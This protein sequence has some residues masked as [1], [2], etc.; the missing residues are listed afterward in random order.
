MDSFAEI[1]IYDVQDILTGRKRALKAPILKG[2]PALPLQGF[3][4]CTMC[5]R[6]LTGSPSKSHTGTYYY[7]YHA[8]ASY[9]CGCRYRAELVNDALI[10][11]LKKY[12]PLPGMAELY[13]M[14]IA[15]IYKMYRSGSSSERLQLNEEITS[16]QQKLSN[17]R[18]LLMDDKIDPSDFKIMK[19]ECEDQL[20]RL[21]LRLSTLTI[22]KS[23]PMSI[24]R[25]IGK[26]IH[27]LSNVKKTYSDGD[28]TTKKEVLGC[29][30]REKLK[31][32]G[33][34]YRT[35]RLNEAARLI[36]HI[37]RG[38]RENING[39][40]AKISHLSREVVSTGIEPISKV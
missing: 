32:D 20:K 8:Q 22:P 24:D 37:N 10:R 23:N 39:K 15:D 2:N 27:A 11:E 26:A 18:A 31:F 34:K 4:D 28:A 13:K 36:Y 16:Y 14:V 33:K 17:A 29:I 40:D 5:D 7:Y 12:T 25:M 35:P 6:K 19:R 9:G 1:P 30:F 38:L 21:E 3:L